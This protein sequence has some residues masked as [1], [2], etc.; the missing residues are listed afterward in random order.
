MKVLSLDEINKQAIT[1]DTLVRYKKLYSTTSISQGGVVFLYHSEQGSKVSI[2]SS[3]VDNRYIPNDSRFGVQ[4]S[5]EKSEDGESICIK[6]SESNSM[7][8]L[9]KPISILILIEQ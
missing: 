6:N 3:E 1:S 5:I 8:I 7:N 9:N 2:L 4:Y